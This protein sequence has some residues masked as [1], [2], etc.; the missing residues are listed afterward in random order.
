MF[1]VALLGIFAV[2]WLFEYLMGLRGRRHV[3][4]A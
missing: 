3:Q 1:V 4:P 2:D